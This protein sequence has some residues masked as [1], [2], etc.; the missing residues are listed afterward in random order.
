MILRLLLCLYTKQILCVK[1]GDN[2]SNYCHVSN[3]V[4]QGGVLSPI[5]FSIHIDELFQRLKVVDMDATLEIN[6][7]EPLATPVIVC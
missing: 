4:K 7:W 6:L 2:I 5:L 1:W 3:G